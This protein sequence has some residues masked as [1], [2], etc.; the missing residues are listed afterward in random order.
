MFPCLPTLL[1]QLLGI[2]KDLRKSR[3]YYFDVLLVWC[4]SFFCNISLHFNGASQASWKASIFKSFS[5]QTVVEI[6]GLQADSKCS[7]S[8]TKG[9]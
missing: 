5:S 6:E 3:K 7:S 1:G 4:Y 8:K 2:I 9:G